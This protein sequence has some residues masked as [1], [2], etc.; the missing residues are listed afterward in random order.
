MGRLLPCIPAYSLD[1]ENEQFV[2]YQQKNKP[3]KQPEYTKKLLRLILEDQA[4]DYYID[5]AKSYFMKQGNAPQWYYP[6]GAFKQQ[7]AAKNYGIM[8][9]LIREYGWPKYSTVG[10]KDRLFLCLDF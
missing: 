5:Q 3:L 9:D 2:K 8:Q 6:I 10:M 1:I 7:I 4:L